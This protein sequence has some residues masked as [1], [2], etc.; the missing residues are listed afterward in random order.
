MIS[1]AIYARFSSHQQREE[2]IDGQVRACREYAAEKNLRV[3]EV[4][5]DRA[6]SGRTDQRPEFQRMIE[7][8]KRKQFSIILVWKGDRIARNRTDKAYYRKLLKSHKVI[9]KSVT[10]KIPDTPEGIIL[11][12]VLDGMDEYY[13]A[14]LAINTKR[15][16]KEN[17]LQ[18]KH[19]GGPVPFGFALDNDKKYIEHPLEAPIVTEIFRQ[20]VRGSAMSEIRAWLDQRSIK[21]ANGKPFTYQQ[22]RSMISNI[23]YTGLYVFDDIE[24]E[25]GCPRLVSEEDFAVA[26]ERLRRGEQKRGGNTE[27]N[28]QLTGK[29][30]CGKCGGTVSGRTGTSHTGKT[31]AYYSCVNQSKHKKCDLPNFRKDDLEEFVTAV[32]VEILKSDYP[33]DLQPQATVLLCF[34]EG[35]GRVIENVWENRF[36]YIDE[37]KKMGANILTSGR[38]AV[39]QGGALTGAE[40][41]AS[42][43]RGGAAMVMAGLSATGETRVANI[44]RI[45]RGYEN[46]VKKLTALGADIRLVS[47]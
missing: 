5:A 31:H 14:N 16:M 18:A 38:L 21:R 26:Q 30:F 33:T 40:V 27:L 45:E 28:F 41:T 2:S 24:V 44:S 34:A 15:G 46:F 29:C 8:A 19:N 9:I 4:Y 43:L 37:L 10:E 42:D 11:E 6:I 47:L 20:Y 23:K 32:A 22:L 36:Q 12:S 1:A 17:A 25:G 39:I 3:V 13:S 7:D 35:S